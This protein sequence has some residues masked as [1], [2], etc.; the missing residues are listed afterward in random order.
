MSAN[1]QVTRKYFA[2][3]V[4]NYS[5][6]NRY[7]M[8]KSYLHTNIQHALASDDKVKVTQCPAVSQQHRT[9]T[10]QNVWQMS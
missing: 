1:C 4:E 5:K 10:L 3:A 2:S 9:G 6:P 8:S 7:L